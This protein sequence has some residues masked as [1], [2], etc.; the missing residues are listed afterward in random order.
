MALQ[1][2]ASSRGPCYPDADSDSWSDGTQFWMGRAGGSA[3]GGAYTN[4]ASGQPDDSGGQD[5]LS[6]REDGTWVDAENTTSRP[7]VCEAP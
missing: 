2:E 7:Y 1:R 5:H 6:V 4:W 3:V